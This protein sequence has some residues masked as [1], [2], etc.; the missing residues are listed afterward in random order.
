VVILRTQ[1]ILILRLFC[2][3]A[4]S[5]CNVQY[6]NDVCG[7]ATANE[8][9]LSILSDF[10]KLQFFDVRVSDDCN[11]SYELSALND[12]GAEV[13]LANSSALMGALN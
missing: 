7:V 1:L 11:V 5:E 10:S 3:V 8:S 4:V 9:N 12:G 6:S 13:C 2:D